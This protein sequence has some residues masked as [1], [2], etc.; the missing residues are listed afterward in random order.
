MSSPAVASPARLVLRDFEHP[1]PY[2]NY[3]RALHDEARLPTVAPL[4]NNTRIAGGEHARG[5][6]GSVTAISRP[7]ANGEGKNDVEVSLLTL[8]AWETSVGEGEERNGGI[9]SPECA[10]ADEEEEEARAPRSFPERFLWRLRRAR[11]GGSR[12]PSHASR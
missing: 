4:P 1:A 8:V 3:T 7:R 9:C 6:R 11:R 12:E 5:G 2:R 10:G